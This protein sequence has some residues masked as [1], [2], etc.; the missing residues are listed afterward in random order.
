M[1]ARNVEDA[2]PQGHL[3]SQT[4]FHHFF[5][6]VL[7]PPVPSLPNS[8]DLKNK[9]CSQNARFESSEDMF[10]RFALN[11]FCQSKEQRMDWFCWTQACE[12]CFWAVGDRCRLLDRKIHSE[13]AQA[14]LCIWGKPIIFDLLNLRV[15]DWNLVR[16]Q[17]QQVLME[18][19]TRTPVNTNTLQG[20]SSLR[21]IQWRL[22]STICWR[23][24]AF[25]TN[26]LEHFM[27]KNALQGIVHFQQV[28]LAKPSLCWHCHWL[29]R[30]CWPGLLL[31]LRGHGWVKQ[32]YQ[33]GSE[34]LC[35]AETERHF[36]I[37]KTWWKTPAVPLLEN[38]FKSNRDDFSII[39]RHLIVRMYICHTSGN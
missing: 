4:L 20:R 33:Q 5:S 8:T 18:K 25:S 38:T 1:K 34:P 15:V 21:K 17:P 16:G 28:S 36:I 24:W 26:V 30:C 9:A 19:I 6:N 29:S 35:A 3:H 23:Q 39:V 12:A 7:R 37:L 31:F 14:W 22:S 27:C 10:W 2:L 11:G 13:W 32:W